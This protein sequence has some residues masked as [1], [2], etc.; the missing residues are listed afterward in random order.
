MSQSLCLATTGGANARS[1]DLG[2]CQPTPC[3]T[4]A[5]AR[6]PMGLIVSATRAAITRKS[7]D[8]IL[9][10]DFLLSA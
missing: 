3:E 10:Y 8:N 4:K 9:F 2:C 7:V 5:L 6:T 1:E